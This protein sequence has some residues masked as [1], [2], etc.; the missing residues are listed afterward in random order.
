MTNL[1]EQINQ[2]HQKLQ[3]LQAKQEDVSNE[4]KA[5]RAAIIQLQKAHNAQHASTHRSPIATPPQGSTA[6]A[7]QNKAPKQAATTG[8]GK[9]PKGKSDLEKFIGEN[10][11]NKIGILI[12]II[13]VAIGA[14]YS[15]DNELISPISRIGLGYLTGILLLALGFKLKGKYLNYSAV[16]MSGAIAI[17]YFITYA[18]YSFYFLMPQSMAFVLM[19]IFT[20]FAVAVAIR[21]NRQVIAHI[22]LV[23]AYAVPILLSDGSGN[24]SVLFSYM[25]IIN[26]GILFI[27]FA[28]YWKQLYYASYGLSWLVFLLW[29]ATEY[30]AEQHFSLALL[31]LAIF[32]AIFYITAIAYKVIRNK[33][34]AIS[35]IALLIGNTF[36]FYSLGFSILKNHSTGE[37]LL[38]W[39]TIGNAVLHFAMSL[40]IYRQ[41]LSDKTLF[42]LLSGLG[43]LFLTLS[44]PVQMNGKWI[45]LL[46]AG[47]AAL[48]FWISRAKKVAFYEKLSYPLMLLAFISLSFE[49]IHIYQNLY[50][51]FATDTKIV[52][53]F[54]THFMTSILFVVA[55]GF[56]NILEQNPKYSSSLNPQ[57]SIR[58]VMRLLIPAILLFSLYYTFYLELSLYWNKLYN[59][60]TIL[61]DANQQVY[62][63]FYTKHDLLHFKTLSLLSYTILFITALS[64]LNLVWIKKKTLS[65]TSLLLSLVATLWLLTNGLEAFS[66]LQSSYSSAG[67]G[68]PSQPS[69]LNIGVRYIVYACTALMLMAAYKTVH[70]DF[71]QGT[72]KTTYYLMLHFLVLLV[73]SY[74]LSSWLEIGGATQSNKLAISILWGLYSLFLIS[75]GIWKKNKPLRIG[76]IVLFG[77]TLFK[78]FLYDIS[79]LNTVAKTIVFVSLGVLLLIISFM[80]NKYKHL[81]FDDS[82]AKQKKETENT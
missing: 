79:Q 12:T 49:W 78:L 30:N 38:G 32:F 61:L 20:V 59:S 1:N 66:A 34:F 56:I 52:P 21:Y 73:A 8:Q 62:P 29:Y 24:V 47:E 80:Y 10:L 25:S 54:N 71:I 14:K 36:I 26:I 19:L 17:M 74:E 48:L 7:I 5:L 72:T 67:T 65:Y 33:A 57:K 3:A 64:W 41:K 77:A 37:A 23:G 45:T 6:Q 69:L 27:A 70:Q 68:L 55:F 75:V 28:K 60:A 43:L 13:G 44:V 31:F 4:M 81:I 9:A 2:L 53:V 42:Y 16:L 22:G 11:I 76:A 63:D 15:I 46:W 39:F 18:A 51:T 58:S 50:S 35:E 82:K 40:I